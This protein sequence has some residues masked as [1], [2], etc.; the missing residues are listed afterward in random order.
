MNFVNPD[1]FHFV[2]AA[3]DPYFYIT[4]L[5]FTSDSGINIKMTFFW[6]NPLRQCHFKNVKTKLDKLVLYS[7]CYF[8]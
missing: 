3:P 8:L 4:N 1:R 7:I 2:R 6:Q 5:C